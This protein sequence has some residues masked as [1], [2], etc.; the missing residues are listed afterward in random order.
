MRR[1]V[2]YLA[3]LLIGLLASA[4]LS[5]RAEVVISELMYNPQGTDLDTSVY[6]EYLSRMGRD[7]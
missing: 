5:A 7:L 1:R 2:A 6:A 4:P 3:A